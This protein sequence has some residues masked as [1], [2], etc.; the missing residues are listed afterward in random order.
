MSIQLKRCAANGVQVG[1]RGR[2]TRVLA[3]TLFA[4]LA[5]PGAARADVVGVGDIIPAMDDPDL[6]GEQLPDLPQ[7]GNTLMDQI[8]LII[9]G[10]TNSLVGGTAT[11]QLTI[12]IPT[13]TDP[14][15]AVDAVIGHNTFGLG[16]V[17]VVGLNSDFRLSNRLIVGREGQAFLE[18]VAGAR[19][20]TTE[21]GFPTP[22]DPEGQYDLVLGAYEG[23]QGFVEING[24]ASLLASTNVSV[25]HSGQ[26]RIDMINGSRLITRNDASIGTIYDLVGND[27]TIGTGYVLVDGAGSRWNVGIVPTTAPPLPGGGTPPPPDAFLGLLRI[28]REGRGTVEV[29]NQGW[30]RVETDTLIGDQPGSNGTAIVS[31]SDSL[32]WSLESMAVGNSTATGELHLDDLGVARA[33]DDTTVGLLGLVEFDGGTLITPSVTSAGVIRGGG[34]VESANVVNNGEIRNAA[35]IANVR[36]RLLFTGDLANNANIESIGGEIEFLGAV[37]NV[38]PDAQ[39]VAIDAILRFGGGVIN[40][41]GANIFL[42]N[43]LIYV[44]AG[45]SFASEGSLTLWAGESTL[46]GDLELAS[47]NILNV[48]LGDPY[49][50]L[51]VV[52]DAALGGSVNIF[53]ADDYL[54]QFGDSFEIIDADSRAGSFTTVGGGGGGAGFW[55]ASYTA[56]S[57]ILNY[58][59]DLPITLMSDFDGNGFVDGADLAILRMNFGLMP[60]TQADGDGN[61]DGRVD[62]ADLLLFQQQLGMFPPVVPAGSANAGTVPEPSGLVLA[63]AGLVALAWKRKAAR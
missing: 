1:R 5:V 55:Q 23:S 12:D 16:L 19:V 44:P 59:S 24:F 38:G 33:D 40:S 13:Q 42:E 10:G 29:R 28:G 51:E 63:A 4:V 58:M 14:L 26:G 7:F 32:L 3:I 9:V 21:I 48:E 20:S 25:G 18:V 61:G 11:G 22:G 52:G 45:Q 46:V 53:L 54:P 50:R 17:R 30:V 37:A 60:A 27:N 41:G 49:S 39:V 62:G 47:T 31:G 2:G 43:T 15:Y 35:G 56:T 57:A 34:R 8:P 6:P 36:E